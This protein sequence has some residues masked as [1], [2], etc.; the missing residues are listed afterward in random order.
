MDRAAWRVAK[1]QTRLKRLSTK[2]KSSA[3]RKQARGAFS[4]FLSVSCKAGRMDS[5]FRGC[6]PTCEP[7]QAPLIFDDL[8][9]LQGVASS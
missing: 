8:M 3:I 2:H 5:L 1:S 7:L 6:G 9:I 4:I